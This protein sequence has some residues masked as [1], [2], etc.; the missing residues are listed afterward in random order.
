[1]KAQYRPKSWY[2]KLIHIAKS[3]LQ[4]EDDLYR[5]NLKELTGKSSCSDMTI[6]DLVKVLEHMKKSGF[7]PISSKGNSPKTRSNKE[8]TMLDKLRQ[9]WI[10][11]HYQ[12]FINDGS[13]KALQTWTT[14]QSKRLNKGVAVEKLEWLKGNMLYSL[15]EQLKKWHMRLLGEVFK[16]RFEQ[17]LTLYRQGKLN[18]EE[19]SELNFSQERLKSAPNTHASVNGA[20]SLYLNILKQHNVSVVK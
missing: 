10:Q 1:M 16:Q 4:L 5:A 17:I 20:Y 9:L 12:G 15:I 2:I 3:Q 11:M 8:H 18:E 14:N 13:D 7:K 6:P 19:M